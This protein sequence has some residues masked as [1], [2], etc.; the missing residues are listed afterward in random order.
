VLGDEI[1]ARASIPGEILARHPDGFYSYDA[2]YIDESGAALDIPARLGESQVE[3]VQRMAIAA[4][5]ALEGYGMARVDFFLHDDGSLLVNEVNTIPGFT[6]VSMYPKLW[7]ASG[8]SASELVTR[9][10]DLALA[11][12]AAR[13]TL[14]TT[15]V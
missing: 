1:D 9:L 7:E 2:K 5:H 12:H 3:L 10:I 13:R 6:A 14:S 11:R 8:M 4:F 15:G